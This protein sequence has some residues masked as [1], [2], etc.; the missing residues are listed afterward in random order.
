MPV[1]CIQPALETD[2]TRQAP[3]YQNC[4]FSKT[5][6]LEIGIYCAFEHLLLVWGSYNPT[7]C[8]PSYARGGS[9]I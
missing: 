9:C 4:V 7:C 8:H 2:P 3:F 6:N 1:C 5:M